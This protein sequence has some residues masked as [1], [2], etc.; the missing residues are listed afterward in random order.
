MTA[1]YVTIPPKRMCKFQKTAGSTQDNC[2]EVHHE[3]GIEHVNHVEKDLCAAS[4]LIESSFSFLIAVISIE[5]NK[6][7]VMLH[8]LIPLCL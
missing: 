6:S 7:C 2:E 4:L 1:K 8:H 5:V 3:K